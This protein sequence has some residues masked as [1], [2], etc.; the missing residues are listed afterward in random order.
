[1]PKRHIDSIDM[2]AEREGS[3]V[4]KHNGNVCRPFG[5][6]RSILKQRR[7]HLDGDKRIECRTVKQ[8]FERIHY[9]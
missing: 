5:W 3:A 9:A 4:R 7:G 2:E 8:K 1:M 6:G